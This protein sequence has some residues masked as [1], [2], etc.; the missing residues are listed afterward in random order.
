[1][2][3]EASAKPSILSILQVFAVQETVD[4]FDP[5]GSFNRQAVHATDRLQKRASTVISMIDSII[6]V[7]SCDIYDY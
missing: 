3:H 4:G 6:V 1:M 7:I 2:S 5:P